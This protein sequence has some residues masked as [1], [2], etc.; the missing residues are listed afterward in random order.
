MLRM[1]W[2]N[3]LYWQVNRDIGRTGGRESSQDSSA[4]RWGGRSGGRMGSARM[5]GLTGGR[6]ARD[7]GFPELFGRYAGLTSGGTR[8]R[9]YY[10]SEKAGRAANIFQEVV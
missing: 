5:V 3:C 2:P 8:R 10:C 9:A 7:I 6:L 4:Q 1:T